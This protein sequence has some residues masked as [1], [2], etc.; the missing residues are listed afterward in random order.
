MARECRAKNAPGR[1]TLWRD[2]KKIII[3]TSICAERARGAPQQCQN[4]EK[5]LQNISQ[6][7]SGFSLILPEKIK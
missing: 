5:N 1:R 4:F 7:Q 2:A 6:L 3:H